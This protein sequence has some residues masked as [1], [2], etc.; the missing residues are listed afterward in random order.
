MNEGQNRKTF[1][2][3]AIIFFLLAIAVVW[4]HNKL[5][6]DLEPYP[7]GESAKVRSI[8]SPSIATNI[9]DLQWYYSPWL[10]LLIFQSLIGAVGSVL[11]TPFQTGALLCC[12]FLCSFIGFF[13]SFLIIPL[14]FGFVGLIIC[15]GI[16]DRKKITTANHWLVFCAWH[17]CLLVVVT[18]AYDSKMW[19]VYGD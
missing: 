16:A 12:S 14:F 2:G 18:F 15:W 4:W 5:L 9:S 3:A 17:N 13:L 10:G 1:I 6:W 11:F 7:G 19:S 8:E